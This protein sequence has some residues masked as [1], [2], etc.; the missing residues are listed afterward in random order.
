MRSPQHIVI[1]HPAAIGDSMMASPVPMVLKKYFPDAKITY[2]SHSS[3]RPLILDMCPYI[4]QFLDFKKESVLRLLAILKATKC[5][6]FVDLSASLRGGILSAFGSSKA[7]RMTK[8]K[9]G[10]IAFGHMVDNFLDTI[11]PVCPK[12]PE[13]LFPTLE[14]EEMPVSALSP[15]VVQLKN[16]SENLLAIVPGVGKLRPNRA[17]P[18]DNWV[19]LI[20]SILRSGNFVP[21]F[22]GGPEEVD[23]GQDL[24]KKFPSCINLCGKLNLAQTAYVL[25]L[26]KLVLSADT[27]PAH[28]AT[29][30]GT[31][32]I[33]LYGP[34]QASRYGPY[35]CRK[36]AIDKS[37]ACKCLY[38]K[39]CHLNSGE[40]SG[41]CMKSISTKSVLEKLQEQPGV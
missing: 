12:I 39:A 26:S 8:K 38:E 16:R 33:G 11:R 19:E 23:L 9:V 31:P 10:D 24:E 36:I 5:D 13:K 2:W 17:W 7:L 29:A 1:F 35:D 34:T 32:V 27:G 20:D 15:D 18:L 28:I 22:I 4:D 41:E 40:S 6:L 37:D 25:K 14:V 30:V 21:V 3:L